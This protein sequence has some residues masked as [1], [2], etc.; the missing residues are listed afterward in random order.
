VSNYP[1]WLPWNAFPPRVVA[2]LQNCYVRETD[3]RSWARMMSGPR[4]WPII[5]RG[6]FAGCKTGQVL[7]RCGLPSMPWVIWENASTGIG[8]RAHHRFAA[9]PDHMADV[10]NRAQPDLV[11]VLGEV[12]QRGI[13]QLDVTDCEVLYGPHPAARMNVRD[14]LERIAQRIEELYEDVIGPARPGSRG[15]PRPTRRGA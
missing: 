8:T 11:V 2:F 9:D 6:L 12:A 4:R 10:I 13:E 14:S 1:D 7:K 15:D 3:V 5:A